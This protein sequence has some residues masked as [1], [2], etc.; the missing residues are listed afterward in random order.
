VSAE[1]GRFHH[2]RDGRQA[3]LQMLYQWEVGRTPIEQVIPAF[4]SLR[5][6]SLDPDAQAFA[7]DLASGTIERLPEIDPLIA[8]GAEHWRLS[9]MAIMDRLIMRMAVYEFLYRT[10]TP[11]KVAIN[12]ALEL[13]KTF[14]T[15]DAVKF[16]NGI[17]DGI[18]K[19]LEA[20]RGPGAGDRGPDETT[21]AE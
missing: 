3:A 7:T 2:R 15:D 12:E 14:S 10:D 20:G 4:L 5:A 6:T 16:I 1:R 19:K 13:A 9:R 17:L 11:A 21:T 18:R 8:A